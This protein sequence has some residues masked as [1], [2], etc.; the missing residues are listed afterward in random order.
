M[1]TPRTLAVA[2]SDARSRRPADAE[3][4]TVLHGLG[5][6]KTQWLDHLEH[7]KPET[8][9]LYTARWRALADLC[10]TLLSSAEFLYLD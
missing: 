4:E 2:P 1:T 8:P 6:L 3:F 9:K 10:R 7:E 5:E